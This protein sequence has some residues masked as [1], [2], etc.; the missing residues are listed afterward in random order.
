MKRRIVIVLGIATVGSLLLLAWRRSKT[1]E[2]PDAIRVDLAKREIRL[3]ATVHRDA[4]SRPLGIKGHHAIVWRGGIAAPWALFRSHASDQQVR[5]ALRQLGAQPGENLTA[6]TWR[7]R[8][9]PSSPEPDKRVEGSGVDV[10]VAWDGA[11]FP[12][13]SII[14]PESRFDFRF[15]GNERWRST[16]RS[17]C[18]VCLYSCPGGVIGSH[19]H[20]IRDY[21]K[22]GPLFSPLT[23]RLPEDGAPVTIILRPR[24]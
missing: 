2:D 24:T 7:M 3:T 23:R 21:V 15:G 8:K 20:T 17:G 14:E 11:E 19:A 16:F 12:L 18:I 13:D 6:G 1:R 5:A 22:S 9:D 10:L 4:M